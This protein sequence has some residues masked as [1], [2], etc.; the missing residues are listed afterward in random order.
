[1]S[2]G[3]VWRDAEV[4][5]PD[6]KGTAQLDQKM[7]GRSPERT[8]GLNPDEW[9]IIGFDIGGGETGHELHVVAVHREHIPEGG[10][11]Y[12]RVAE[13]NG[14]EIPAT[15]F[16]VHDVDPYEFLRAITHMFEL[17]MRVRGTRDLPIRIT[18]QSDLPPQQ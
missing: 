12:P 17:R 13:A 1:M 3:F 6:W 16:L 2:E 9:R 5:Y 18:R 15:E 4:T 7:T 14:G 11:V 8:V 10:D